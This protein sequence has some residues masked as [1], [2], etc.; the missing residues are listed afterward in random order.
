MILRLIFLLLGLFLARRPTFAL[1]SNVSSLSA[2]YFSQQNQLSWIFPIISQIGLILVVLHFFVESFNNSI[3]QKKFR[4]LGTFG[5]NEILP[6]RFFYPNLSHRFKIYYDFFS[7]LRVWGP[8]H[9]HGIPFIKCVS[10]SR[11]CPID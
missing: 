1:L 6:F 3:M 11:M 4:G 10:F 7:L 2:L 8:D 9:L 5:F